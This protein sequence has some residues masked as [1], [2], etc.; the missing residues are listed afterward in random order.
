M[1]TITIF[2]RAT[3]CIAR[4][5]LSSR[6]RH[7]PVLIVSK[8]INLFLSLVAPLLWFSNVTY[9]WEIL[10]GRGACHSEGLGHFRSENARTM[11]VLERVA[12]SLVSLH[13]INRFFCHCFQITLVVVNILINHRQSGS[14]SDGSMWKTEQLNFAAMVGEVTSLAELLILGAGPNKSVK[15]KPSFLPFPFPSL[16]L[17]SRPLKSS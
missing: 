13:T 16:P 14:G 4:L 15:H 9:G 1:L 3:L 17:R 10:T 8:P 11:A 6:V 7:T 2:A 5:S 12:D